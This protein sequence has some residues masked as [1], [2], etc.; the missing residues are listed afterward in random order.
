MISVKNGE[1]LIKGSEVEL[2]A[3][4]SCIIRALHENF[5]KVGGKERSRVEIMEAVDYGFLSDEEINKILMK[6]LLEIF[7]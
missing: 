7:K 5:T 3:D 6:E 1:V 4:L 2:L